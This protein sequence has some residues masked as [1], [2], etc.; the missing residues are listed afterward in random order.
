MQIVCFRIL[1][2]LAAI[3]F[4]A[5]GKH[6]IG[7]SLP[8]S[9]EKA[10]SGKAILQALEMGVE[11][12]NANGGAG[13]RDIELVVRDDA[14]DPAKSKAISEEFA[15]DKSILAVLGHYDD[16]VALAGVP[17]Y[18]KGGV[19]IL[20]PSV[21]GAEF[22]EKSPWAFT[23]TYTLPTQMKTLSAYIKIIEELD[24]VLVIKAT[25]TFGK[26]ATEDFRTAAEADG[27]RVTVAEGFN[28][29]K[30]GLE[31]DFVQK[32]IPNASTYPA[33]VILAHALNA[34]VLIKQLRDAGFK[35]II[36]GADR[37]AT[38]LIP[39]LQKLS[40]E[41]GNGMNY[42]ERVNIAFPFLYTLGSLKGMRFADRY[43]TRFGAEPT[44][45]AGFGYDSLD[46][47]A[48][49]IQ[50]KG[51]DRTAIRDWLAAQNSYDEGLEGVSGRVFFAEGRR[52][53]GRE[54]VMARLSSNGTFKAA[55]RQIRE[56]RDNHNLRQVP[57]KVASGEIV[58]NGNIPYFLISVVYVGI[59][60]D[61]INNVDIK[62]QRFEVEGYMWYRWA[63]DVDIENIGFK[64][65]DMAA[66][67]AADELRKRM[68]S[69]PNGENWI[70]YKIRQTLIFPFDLKNFPFDIQHLPLVIAHK[71]RN[72]NKLMIAIDM[73]KTTDAK[74]S[75]IYPQEWDYLG[76][77]DFSGT[78]KIDS[79]FG[80]PSYK[81]GEKQAP[82]SMYEV[83]VSVR[84]ILSPYINS[85]F[86]P[87]FVLLVI[88]FLVSALPLNQIDARLALVMTALLS[89]IVFQ[90]A[91]SSN[92]PSVGYSMKTDIYFMVSYIFLFLMVGKTIAVNAIYNEGNGDEALAKRIE[93][94]F[95]WIAIPIA[96]ISY[97][98][99]TIA[100]FLAR[101]ASTLV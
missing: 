10:E 50:E 71:T 101:A 95:T 77:K 37:L 73:E 11:E 4:A 3:F 76:R 21:G 82:F 16:S 17:A 78:F 100:G 41:S 44:I 28:D 94:Y 69:G 47:I 48:H 56:V 13:G 42:T 86:I 85:F 31:P 64:N 12:I 46:L 49:A 97:A 75:E 88:G 30:A 38:G 6:K 36:F 99:V 98:A 72:A 7:V 8:L 67:N 20:S 83:R 23:A 74:I 80:N 68:G 2:V 18:D 79:V 65:G 84:R 89:V 70:S 91:M 5:C 9:G 43:K 90:M 96:A 87:L 62:G 29:K 63:G 26:L 15:A 52:A 22:I 45:W 81:I 61:K 59:D 39:K 34:D 54:L 35:G 51:T 40:K 66:E 92:L 60:F 58:M 33:I 25:S 19:V 93:K 53:V 24:N 32:N 57:Q 14:N 27:I 55:Y 1:I